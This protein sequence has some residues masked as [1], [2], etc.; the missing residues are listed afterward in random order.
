[1]LTAPKKS[2]RH[3]RQ[4]VR[5]RGVDRRLI[6]SSTKHNPQTSCCPKRTCTYENSAQLVSCSRDPIGYRGS[7]WNLY[8][9]LQSGPV[10]RLDPFGL[11]WLDS[12]ADLIDPYNRYE[13]ILTGRPSTRP[14]RED[15]RRR[16]RTRNRNNRCSEREPT[17]GEEDCE[18]NTWTDDNPLGEWAFHGNNDCYRSGS[19]QCCYDENG[20]LISSGGDEGTYDYSPYDPTGGDS[21]SDWWDH[22]WNDVLPHVFDDEYYELTEVN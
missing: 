8:E 14:T 12:L 2:P 1:M 4:R 6:R 18:G 15:R 16:H 13:E 22:V 10:L 9:F 20:D 7:P 3:P 19:F 21:W 5:A 17:P 11:D